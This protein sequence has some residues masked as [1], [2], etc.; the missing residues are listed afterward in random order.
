MCYFRTINNNDSEIMKYMLQDTIRRMS[1]PVI[2]A[3][4]LSASPM[5]MAEKLVILHT[6]DT[7][8]QVDPIESSGLGGIERRAAAIDSVRR[9]ESNVLVVDAGD[10]V[11]GS[12]YFYLYGGVVEQKLLNALGTDLRILGNHEFDNGI[13]SLA[14]V[15]KLSEAKNLSTNYFLEDS[16]LEGMF[17]PYDIRTYGDK[18]IGFIALNLD[19]KGMIADGNYDGL[20]FTD[21][22]PA[23]NLT[24]RYLKEIEKV[25]AVVALTHIGY[26]PARKPGDLQLARASKDIDIIIGG[27]SHDTIGPDDARSVVRNAD[28][29]DVLVV[30]TG[31]SGARLGKIEIELD[32]LR[33]GGRPSYELITLDGRFDGRRVARIE[34]IVNEYRPGV[35][36]LMHL[37]LTRADRDMARDDNRMLNYMADFVFDQGNELAPGIDLAIINKGGLRCD[38]PKG[39]VSKGQL[40]NLVPFRNNIRVLDLKGSDLLA[41]LDSMAITGGNGVSRQVDAVYDRDAR[42]TVRATV[43]GKDVDPER[44]YRIA[45]IDYLANGGDY[46]TPLRNGR[47]VTDSSGMLYDD[48]VRY[49]TSGKGKGRPFG[50][51]EK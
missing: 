31:K 32:S 25:D 37:W 29:R 12:L 48:L 41:V 42:R 14:S 19:P 1:L 40:I 2:A 51:G 21:I 24:A 46:L 7:H 33:I 45:T 17:S 11:Q 36:S 34:D 44:T 22:I 23:A 27:H 4:L 10:A 16:A 43:G 3:A 9:A 28:G 8:S 5:L 47:R 50:D 26:D 6:N 18:R 49:V 38:I 15:L 13:D 39:K 35:D 30:Q 20:V